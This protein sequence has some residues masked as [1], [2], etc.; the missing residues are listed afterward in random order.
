MENF[1]KKLKPTDIFLVLSVGSDLKDLV[2][3]CAN[4]LLLKPTGIA[5]TKFDETTQPGKVFSILDVIS[6]PVACFGDGKRI[7]IDLEKGNP[8]YMYDKIFESK[9]K[10]I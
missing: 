9:V 2:L 8:Q 6:L 5:F 3:L 10:E 4:Y 1:I 7:F